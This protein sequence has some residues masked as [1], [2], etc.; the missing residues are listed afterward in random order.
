MA[1]E[2]Q[3]TQNVTIDYE[4]A[5][6]GYR[7]LAYIVDLIII[8]LW[9]LGWFGILSVVTSRSIFDLF[10]SSFS[11]GMILLSIIVV[12]V[13]FYDLLFETMN[14]GQS[15]GKM[16]FKI[17]VT[18]IEGTSPSL[19]AYLLRWLFRLVD[20]T[21]TEW[22]LGIVMIAATKNS[23][24]L[25]DMIAGTTVIDLK[26]NNKN[27]QLQVPD[28][29][30]HE[31]YKVTYYDVLDRLSDK[32]VQTIL[33][34]MRDCSMSHDD[35]FISRLSDRIKQISGYSYSGSDKVFLNKIINDYNYLA[36]Q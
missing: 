34:I 22:I 36:L 21:I 26:M 1:I 8:A 3:T 20:F 18:N 31:D 10:D 30:F 28:L 7:L 29:D 33:S 35:F 9:I 14:N 13:L 4:P 5:G 24:R 25:G 11:S 32:D 2:V 17:R 27:N 15:L 6:I 16:I 23:Q 12:P 19:G